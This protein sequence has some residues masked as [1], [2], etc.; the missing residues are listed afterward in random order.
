MSRP[1]APLRWVLVV[2]AEPQIHRLVRVLLGEGFQVVG[3]KSV[4]EA[5]SCIHD[6]P[7]DVVLSEEDLGEVSG[8]DLLRKLRRQ[9][10]DLAVIMLSGGARVS[11]AV[12]AMR[13]GAFDYL[14]KTV[15]ASE[16]RSA[17]ERA[18]Q[19]GSL[20]R[21][22]RRLRGEV[23]SARGL[24]N[25]VGDSATM[26]QLLSLAQRVANSDATVL[27]VGE[28]GT[29]KE[30]LSRII[31]RLGPRSDK[32]FVAFDCSALA[33]TLLETELFGHEKG[34]FTG[35]IGRRIGRF[36]R[37]TGGTLFLDEI[38]EMSQTV[39]IKLL[40][41][42]Q[43]RTIRR[44]GGNVEIPVNVRI[45]AATNQDLTEAIERGDFREDLFYR[46]DV[47]PIVL[48][49]LRERRE[50]IPMMVEHFIE[51]F[52]SQMGTAPKK[53][54]VDAMEAIETY[55]WPGN[56]RELENV[57]ER[58]VALDPGEV[59]T[60]RSLPE[61]VT[62]D[63]HRST[64]VFDLPSEGLDLESHLEEIGKTLM[65]RALERTGGVQKDAAEL[66]GM[67]FRS[68]RY[69][70]KKYGL[71]VKEIRAEAREQESDVAKN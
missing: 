45:I 28:S 35:A 57:I 7:F 58:I 66:L 47:I 5:M 15:G 24:G 18:V 34:A 67:S 63:S 59:I 22:V 70:A 64:A 56:V 4:A 46:I 52:A 20:T 69:H 8:F 10:P 44:V 61:S 62:G 33:P 9:Y 51:K 30:L 2:D 50:D 3:A 48:P 21:E 27:I 11:S 14:R 68:F 41:V 38:G 55:S 19:H 32:P 65:I 54:S 29:G 6:T 13:L 17:V 49:P 26:H 43:E 39:Q 36:E 40:R 31:H 1:S 16:L 25:L 71:N 60:R 23:E 53:V 42:L 37:A 12:E